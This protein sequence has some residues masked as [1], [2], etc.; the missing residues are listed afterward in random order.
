MR[1]N[2][3]LLFKAC[4]SLMQVGPLGVRRLLGM[5]FRERCAEIFTCIKKQTS[6]PQ[7]GTCSGCFLFRG[8]KGPTPALCK[9]VGTGI[10]SGSFVL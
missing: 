7:I 5:L 10:D 4:D 8:R 6:I 2:L 1:G 3:F 9:D